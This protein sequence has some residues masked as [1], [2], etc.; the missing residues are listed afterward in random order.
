[1]NA[2]FLITYQL[3][4]LNQNEKMKLLRGLY[5][6][7]N[8]KE[9]AGRNGGSKVYFQ[10]GLL[11]EIR[12]SKDEKSSGKRVGINCILVPADKFGKVRAFFGR[13]KLKLEVVEV[14]LK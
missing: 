2:H 6:Y 7:S 4:E 8:K 9:S 3:N 14:F 5:G 11:D 10:K 12:E 1:M 13:F